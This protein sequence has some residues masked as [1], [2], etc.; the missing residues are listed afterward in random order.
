MSDALMALIRP[1]WNTCANE[2]AMHKLLTL[3]MTTWNAALLPLDKCTAMLDDLAATLPSE[4]RADFALV[5]EPLIRRKEQLFPHVRRPMLS[6][7]LTWL[8]AG[9]PYLTVLSGL[10]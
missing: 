7:D 9:K 1:E 4:L 5:I 2:E 8:A 3:G 6:Y 10:S